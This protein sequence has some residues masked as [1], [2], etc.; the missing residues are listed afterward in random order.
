MNGKKIIAGGIASLFFTLPVSA[1]LIERVDTHAAVF[2]MKEFHQRDGLP[3]FFKKIGSQRQVHIGYIGGSITEVKE[4][5]AGLVFSWFKLNYPFTAFY[6]TNVAIGG[7]GSDLG[8]FRIERDLLVHRPDLVFIEFAVND[9]GRAQASV[10]SSMEGM[11]RK[12]WKDNSEVD[13]CLVYTTAKEF[14]PGLVEGTTAETIAVMEELADYYQIPSINMGLSIARLYAGGKLTLAADPSE[15]ARTIVFSKDGVHPLVESGHPLYAAVV[16]DHIRQLSRKDTPVKHVLPEP[17][18]ANDWGEAKMIDLSQTSLCGDWE[19]L[20]ADHP[21]VKRN[22]TSMPVIYKGKPGASM[23][24]R[25]EG[26]ALGFFDCIGPGTGIIDIIIDGKGMERYRFDPW[27]EG[28][29]RHNFLI[30]NLAFGVHEVEVRVTDKPIDKKA[31][32]RKNKVVIDDFKP[33][34]ETCWYPANV[35][36]VGEMIKNE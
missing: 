5:W 29:R 16:A 1:Q 32:M 18:A 26:N 3:N 8:V 17:Y 13:I 12:I 22:G 20:P 4:G 24:F 2:N 19:K 27:C 35:L 25:F 23:R 10:L 28:Y 6:Q 30:D 21:V 33:Y 9:N 14:I 31:I 7:T 15:N 11:I 36:I 34:S